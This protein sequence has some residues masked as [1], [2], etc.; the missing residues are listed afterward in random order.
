MREILFRGKELNTGEWVEGYFI[1]GRYYLNEEEINAIA[2]LDL[3]FFPHCELS[4]YVNVVPETVGQ[5]TGLTDKNGKRIFE[6]DIVSGLFFF[7]LSVNAVV[8]FQDGAFGLEQRRGKIKTFWAFTSVCNVEYE[9]L[10]NIHDSP[11]LLKG[12]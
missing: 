8:T 5:F 10:G 3:A 6:G 11:E 9:V 4:E 1:K 12:D 2:P 7:G